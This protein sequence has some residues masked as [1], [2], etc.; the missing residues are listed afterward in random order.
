[1]LSCKAPAAGTGGCHFQV[2][3]PPQKDALALL[4]KRFE[5]R[6][7]RQG[8]DR[9]ARPLSLPAGRFGV[10]SVHSEDRPPKFD[11]STST[12]STVLPNPSTFQSQIRERIRFSSSDM[13]TKSA[14]K[15]NS[16]HGAE[17]RSIT[18][19]LRAHHKQK[20]NHRHKK[21]TSVNPHTNAVFHQIS[22][23]IH[24]Q[25][26]NPPQSSRP[27]PCTKHASPKSAPGIFF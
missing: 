3:A 10:R 5:R 13:E 7:Y 2:N 8:P 24:H 12:T 18:K 14:Q 25:S 26:G 16:Q 9:P 15:C 11:S 23:I 22:F 6:T 27:N 19:D 1:M 21:N 20:I 17:F 4:A